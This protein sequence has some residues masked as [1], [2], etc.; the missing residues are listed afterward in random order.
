MDGLN[1]CG[2]CRGARGDRDRPGVVEDEGEREGSLVDEGSSREAESPGSG[3]GGDKRFTE[4]EGGQEGTGEEEE[5]AG[6]DGGTEGE[7]E[8]EG[9][10]VDGARAT[11]EEAGVCCRE[12]GEIQ[13]W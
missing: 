3:L 5:G 6:E 4:M 8:R 10:E 2:W 11:G 12:R 9:S 7:I 1:S 13:L